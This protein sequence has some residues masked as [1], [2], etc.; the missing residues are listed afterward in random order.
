MPGARARLCC[1]H[2]R[3]VWIY[4]LG[5]KFSC[6]TM[7]SYPTPLNNVQQLIFTSWIVNETP[8]RHQQEQKTTFKKQILPR[9]PIRNFLGGII[10]NINC[11]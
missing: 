6:S 7:V 5:D 11:R 2:L 10:S 1:L 3:L 8:L 9:L 4:R